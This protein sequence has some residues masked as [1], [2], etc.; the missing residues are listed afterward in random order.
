MLAFFLPGLTLGFSAAVSPGPF[1]AYVIAQAL[2]LGARRALPAAFAPLLSDGP[3]IA[4]ALLALSRLPEGF[5][6]AIR[7][8]GGVYVLFLA[9]KAFQAY[10]AFQPVDAAASPGRQNILQA[11]LMNF[12]S[13]GPYLFWSVL[14]GPLLLQG[15]RKTPARGIA[16]LLGFY[17]ALIGGTA[18]L[19]LLFGGARRLGPR[20]NRALIGLSALAM[21]VF[22]LAQILRI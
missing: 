5:L 1:Q 3:I 16:F 6:A 18:A 13:P 4:L 20:I 15:W 14:A 10:R 2:R 12:L 17:G 22:G 11:A 8:A 21:A 7:M 9:W 19:I